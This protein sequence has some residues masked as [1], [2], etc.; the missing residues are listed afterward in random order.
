M[1]IGVICT[2]ASVPLLL[3]RLL[4]FRSEPF[5]VFEMSAAALLITGVCIIIAAAPS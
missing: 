1:R 3:V 4:Y 2:I 5:V